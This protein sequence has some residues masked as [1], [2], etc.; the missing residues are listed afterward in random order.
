VTLFRLALRGLAHRRRVAAATAAGAA[1]ATAV[2]VAAL[3]AG[4]AVRAS[5]RAIAVSRLGRAAF[6]LES[7]DRFFRSG[8][9]AEAAATAGGEAAALVVAAA[10][11]SARGGELRVPSVQALGVAD[12]FAAMLPRGAPAWSAP[13]P[14]RVL[15]NEPLARR[16]DAAAGDEVLL[17]FS[18]AGTMP[19]EAPL[20]AGD[21]GSVTL[22][23]VVAGVV[24]EEALGSFSLRIGGTG[25]V[26]A[27]VDR[28]ELASVLGRPGRANVLLAAPPAGSG[29]GD[30]E[31]A[32]AAR[33][34]LEDAG[35]SLR[36]LDD[37]WELT[38]DRV[39]I[40][41][42]VEV[43]A[44][45]A[46]GTGRLA[47]FV[48]RIEHGGRT[49]WYSFVSSL[50]PPAPA[51][52]APRFPADLG[53]DEVVLNDWA[54]RELGARP[55]DTVAMAFRVPATGGDLEER[56]AT[57]TVRA[58]V[59][60]EGDDRDLMPSFPGFS[61]AASCRDWDPGVPLDLSRI[62]PRDE[63]YWNRWGG[64]PRAFVTL[65]A[66]RRLWANR[67]GGLTAVRFPEDTP[68]PADLVVPADLGLAVAPVL[69]EALA[70][71]ASGVDFG[72]LFLGLG[73]FL[74]AGALA[75]TA[76]LALLSVDQRADELATLAAFGWPRSRI[77]RLALVEG[78]FVALAGGLA[79]VPLG[80]A[81][82]RGIVAGLR[83]AWHD[84]VRTPVLLPRIE[85][86]SLAVGFAAGAAVSLVVILLAT[87]GVLRRTGRR[88]SPRRR[89]AVPGAAAVFALLA[90][91]AAVVLLPQPTA[92]FAG[93]ALLLAGLLAAGAAA[94]SAADRPR[95]RGV[96]GLAGLGLADAAR[97]GPRSLAVAAVLAFG[98]F[99]VT[100]VASNSLG[101]A[102]SARRDSGTGGFDLF[103]R[104]SLP[105]TAE[106]QRRLAASLPGSALVGLRTIDGDD[107]SCLNLNRVAA[108]GILAV[109]PG[110]MA[111]R[112]AFAAVADTADGAVPPA[113]GDDGA[114]GRTK[115][116]DA[117]A[118]PWRLLE[119]DLGPD[120]IPAFVDAS[121]L[122]WG[123]GL[124][125]GDEIPYVDEAGRTLRVRLVA[126]LAG[127][128][129][130][131]S[132]VAAESAVL[133]HFPSTPPARVLLVDA[134][135]GTA[136]DAGADAAAA[137]S[138]SLATL[139]ADVETTVARLARFDSVQNTYLA[140]F[141]MLGW[142]G[143]LVGTLGLAVV[144]VRNVAQSRGEL[145]L[146]RAVGF[147][148]PALVALVLAE[149]LPAVAGGLA[150]G[151]IASLVAVMPAARLLAGALPLG[152]LAVQL[153]TIVAGAFAAT[154]ASAA[155]ALH[156]DLAP[157]LREE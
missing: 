139:G 41:P 103:V 155:V 60:I 116:E 69:E 6:A 43:A 37:A 108:P 151:A 121:V 59:P 14:G 87:T 34:A 42:A 80:V 71:T 25:A 22:R 63:E 152:T 19:V 83:T 23:L 11:A 36:K 157:A 92:F 53:D 90:A 153:G 31:R 132:L 106:R 147:G 91:V 156:A 117:T 95:V 119:A 122:T 28:G 138:R 21:D 68:P 29:P 135:D 5:L 137:V 65:E 125:L 86:A 81:F 16:L 20:A 75:L 52:S 131:G 150:A 64:S 149:H 88:R 97:R 51:S 110:A 45:G 82:H 107:A 7:G 94:L 4:D 78:S 145:A 109:D 128:V 124:R 112:F 84:A 142:L 143:M 2:L 85:P 38:S 74:A 66:A 102:D 27:F 96:P 123:L 61:G 133:R 55:G 35:L 62:E 10:T 26:N 18:A 129:F 39:F 72:Q 57:F 148:R 140:V 144:V 24:P 56:T 146:L 13:D 113:P 48:D 54:A 8:L 3:G 101:P 93:G 15:L 49:L 30:V 104:A 98:V 12:D 70:A 89:A 73:F 115:A 79:G 154:T 111:G 77:R 118:D 99:I 40:E 33:F 134:P 1:V 127:S 17:R 46:G 58:I 114:S 130:Q 9:A 126:T 50:T 136:A 76:L 120:T 44:L 141:S 47:Y 67:F 100:A 105:V 32:L